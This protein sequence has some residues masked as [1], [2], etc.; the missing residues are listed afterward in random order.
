M[1]KGEHNVLGGVL[2]CA[3]AVHEMVRWPGAGELHAALFQLKGGRGVLILVALNRFVIDEV[4][5]IQKH[6]A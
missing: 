6:L 5:D 2:L 4:R 3:G 1:G